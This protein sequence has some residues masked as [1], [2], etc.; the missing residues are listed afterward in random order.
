M[1]YNKNAQLTFVHESQLSSKH[2]LV[3]ANVSLAPRIVFGTSTGQAQKYKYY[4]LKNEIDF[5]EAELGQLVSP[6][7]KNSMPPH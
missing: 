3:A 7:I 1:V 6:Q 2:H 5:K 4:T